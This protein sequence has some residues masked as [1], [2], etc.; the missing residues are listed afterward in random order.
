MISVFPL[1]LLGG[2]PQSVAPGRISEQSRLHPDP[3]Q[4]LGPTT[5]RL[6]NP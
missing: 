1:N 4:L 2:S 3:Y 6:A 5:S